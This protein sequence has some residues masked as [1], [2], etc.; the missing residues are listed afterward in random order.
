MMKQLKSTLRATQV[1]FH[2]KTIQQTEEVGT[3]SLMMTMMT[4]K[5]AR[6]KMLYVEIKK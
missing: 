2:R 4:S 5:N 6:V 1:F 3:A